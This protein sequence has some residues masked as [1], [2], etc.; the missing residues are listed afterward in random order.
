M[1]SKLTFIIFT[2]IL[3][4]A[5]QNEETVKMD[6]IPSN[7]L[8]GDF[9]VKDGRIVFSE[10]NSYINTYKILL[11]YDNQQLREWSNKAGI[12]PLQNIYNGLNEDSTTYNEN[13]LKKVHG[14]LAYIYNQDGV[15]Q[16]SDTILVIKDEKIISINDGS[17]IKLKNILEGKDI[18][19]IDG[20]IVGNH[21]KFLKQQDIEK[22]INGPMKVTE[23]SSMYYASD[24]LRY[25]AKFEAI[26]IDIAPPVYR[27]A[28]FYLS[29][30]RQLKTLGI[31]W[32]PTET[33]IQNSS[34]KFSGTI[35]GANVYS[36]GPGRAVNAN[37]IVN[38][39]GPYLVYPN[40]PIFQVSVTYNFS[41]VDVPHSGSKTIYYA[42]EP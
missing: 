17:E 11:T 28:E 8:N 29:G 13:F 40:M 14:P 12:S 42:N 18:A 30:R 4:A 3:F 19:S 24:R 32:G 38:G 6:N 23:H 9:I 34:I 5:C 36:A 15:L 31:W 27:G 35:N 2:F 33:P 7:K 37:E 26:T 10:L 39:T 21:T 41:L 20:I 22:T 16:Y 1:K 25:Y